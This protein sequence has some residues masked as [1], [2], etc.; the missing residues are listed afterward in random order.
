MVKVRLGKGGKPTEF[1]NPLL[2]VKAHFGTFALLLNSRREVIPLSISG[3]PVEPLKENELY[4]IEL[5]SQKDMKHIEKIKHESKKL[6]KQRQDEKLKAMIIE[7]DPNHTLD[8]DTLL[9]DIEEMKRERLKIAR[10]Q[11]KMVPHK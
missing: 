8:H 11:K 5:P 3:E 9:R 4:T 1:N 7:N 6:F 2:N 10:K